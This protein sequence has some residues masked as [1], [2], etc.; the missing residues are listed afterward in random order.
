M[1]VFSATQALAPAIDR[2][3]RILFNPFRWTTFLKLCAVAVFTEGFGGNA[4]FSS[5]S[6]AGRPT[7]NSPSLTN[8][9]FSPTFPPFS[10][11]PGWIALIIAIVLAGIVIGFL[12]LYL[13]TR[14]RFSLFYCLAYQVKEIRPGWTLYREQANRFFWFNL[15]VGLL[16][17]FL[18]V[19][20]VAPFVFG[21]FRI[22]QSTHA[23]AHFDIPLFLSL[24]FPML[25]L[26]I[27][28][29]LVAI[30]IDIVLRDFM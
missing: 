14:L 9:A 28:I 24:L 23:G 26:L 17:M 8:A 5:P 18:V 4:N 12:I 15:V 13:I 19:L 7:T 20:A 16:F 30:S 2:T 10:L 25:A 27:V 22:Y 1:I 11:T 6:H 3:R 29:A 21:F